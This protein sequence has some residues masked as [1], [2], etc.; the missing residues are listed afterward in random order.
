[1]EL[2]HGCCLLTV[3]AV[4]AV[5]GSIDHSFMTPILHVPSYWEEL[6]LSQLEN[7]LCFSLMVRGKE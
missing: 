4:C 3:P 1:M 2:E 7:L 6:Y 5:C